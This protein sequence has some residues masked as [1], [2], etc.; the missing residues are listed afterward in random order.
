MIKIDG[1]YLSGGGQIVR[2]ALAL[3][4]LT[5]IPFEVDNIRAGR[6]NPGLKAQHLTGVTSLKE[7]CDAKFEGAEI[8]S[9]YLKYQPGK[10]KPRTIAIDIGTA[11]SITL[12]LQSLLLPCCF[13]DKNTRLKIKGGTDVSWA[14]QWDYFANVVLPHI[15]KFTD[16]IEVKLL[17]RGY[18][19]AGGGNVEIKIKPKFHF[20]EFKTFE[21]FV[22]HVK[23][24]TRQYDL[25]GNYHLMSIKGVSHASKDLAK[26]EVA[27]RQAKSAKHSLL[28]LNVPVSISTEYQD[29][30]ST[31]SGITIWA[32]YSKDKNE[33]DV[34]NPIVLGAD[35]LGEKG[36]SS[37]QVGQNVANKL[38]EQILSEAAVDEHLADN[39]IPWLIFGGSF[40]VSKITNHTLTNIYT[41]ERFLGS[42]FN[43]D[44]DKKIIS[45]R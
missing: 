42:T 1:N 44:T 17:K 14:L 25:T 15:R 11:G 18:Y 9:S 32:I 24:E 20:S 30:L 23:K 37:E 26:A 22:L 16:K 31:G 4:T 8:G 36:V 2:T 7:L 5:G 35:M 34:L 33:S 3:S 27:E 19:P 6:E 38:M 13:A 10:F 21:E 40:R 41:V 43:V 28:K 39:L 29:T 12:L 45:S